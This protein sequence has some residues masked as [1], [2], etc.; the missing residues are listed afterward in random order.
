[1]PQPSQEVFPPQAGDTATVEAAASPPQ[2]EHPLSRLSSDPQRIEFQTEDGVNLMGYYYPSKF[3]DA[4]VFILMHWAGGDLCDWSEIA[5]WLQNRADESPADIE[6]CKGGDAAWW[7]ASWF[8]NMNPDTS[9]AVFVFDFRG[10]GES[11]PN[12]GAWENM[13]LDALAAFETAAG[14]DGVDSN[15]MAA[16]GASIG[17][18]GAPDGC[19]LYNQKA[20]SGCAGALSLSPGNYLGMNYA[21]T[22]SDLAPIPVW[23]FASE[24]DR[25]SAPT[26]E[27]ASGEAYRTEVYAGNNHGMMLLQPEL[28]PQPMLL[29]QEFLELVFGVQVKE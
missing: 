6:R 1:L 13:K 25:E 22:V 2:E 14:F 10:Y 9:L 3:A 26:C 16:M 18:D 21:S 19:L 8:P 28:E 29:I 11:D 24:D 17:A 23:C 4:P 7:D 12:T 20:G 27:G 15:R 5:P